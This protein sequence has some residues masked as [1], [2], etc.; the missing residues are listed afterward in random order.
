MIPADSS[1][2]RGQ[3]TGDPVRA[4]R[5]RRGKQIKA[6]ARQR[7]SED[8]VSALRGLPET[9]TPAVLS[10]AVPLGQMLSSVMALLN[11]KQARPEHA[12][13]RQWADI[14]GNPQRAQRC[15]LQRIGDDGSL[16]IIVPNAVLRSE[17]QFE[18]PRI[19]A[20]VRALS[21]CGHIRAIVFR[22]G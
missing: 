14:V 19:L 3:R 9:A 21:G 18:K 1:D 16:V 8:L 2:S 11:S 22:A 13:A 15:A 20:R 10:P 4:A 7:Q 5:M 6:R 12:I 17:L